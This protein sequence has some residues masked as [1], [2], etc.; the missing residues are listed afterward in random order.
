MMKSLSENKRP[1]S[2]MP[3]RAFGDRQLKDREMRVLGALCAFVNRAG[4]CYPSMETIANV[5]GYN[6]R[7]T[8]YD[9][10][11]GLKQRGY[12]RQLNPK[13]YQIAASGWK[14]NRYQVLWRGDEDLPTQEDI[15]SAKA[16]QVRADQEDTHTEDIG[17]LG[18]EQPQGDTRAGELCWAYIRAVQQAT[19]QV[20]LYDNE[21][22]HARRLAL[23]DVGVADVRA[24]T[25]TVCDQALERRAGVPSLADVVTYI[26]VQEHK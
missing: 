11:K 3:M 25:L 10:V 15:L 4:V 2:V 7:K 9:A 20:R 17:G 19:G 23:R 16:L 26:D 5:C 18:D 6:E 13:D 12:V 1:F 22:A 24:A 14:T 21:I 8:I